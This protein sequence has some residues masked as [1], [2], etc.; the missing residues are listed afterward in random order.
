MKTL[1]PE[2]RSAVARQPALESLLP[3]YHF[4]ER[5]SVDEIESTPEGVIAAICSFD[6]NQ[7]RVISSLL[8]MRELPGRCLER[9]RPG[10]GIPRT[11]KRFGLE[12]FALLERNSCEAVFGLAGRFWQIDLG[13]VP[14]RDVESFQRLNQPGVAR[15]V[16]SFRVTSRAAT[17]CRLETVTRVL[18]S[19]ASSLRKMS[20]YWAL[21]RP[22]SG[23]IRGRILR[24]VKRTTEQAFR[25]SG[26]A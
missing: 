11:C 13:L 6:G 1:Q 14:V 26:K 5:H 2:G 7:D 9:L 16:L 4:E 21:I 19:D 17:R 20:V 8:W 12:N 10:L 3:L 22:F 18:C 23:W 15:L 24:Q 25:A